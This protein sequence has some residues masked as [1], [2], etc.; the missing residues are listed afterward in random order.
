MKVVIYQCNP[1]N[2]PFPLFSW[3]IKY[4]QKTNY[5]HYAIRFD[6]VVMDATASSVR[7]QTDS[8][9]KKKY[10]VINQYEIETDYDF[11]SLISWGMMHINKGYGFF[12]IIGLLM[13]ILKLRKTN[14]FGEDADRLICNELVMLLLRDIKGVK[15]KDS[16]LYDLNETNEILK[17]VG[18]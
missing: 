17:E 7:F 14:P 16:D 15:I 10:S 4:F 13:I 2:H 11:K 8:K 1:L 6:S 9:F 5:S 3:L 18:I 12:Q